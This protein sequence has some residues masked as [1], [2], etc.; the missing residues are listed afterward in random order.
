MKPKSTSCAV[1]IPS[2][3]LEYADAY[4]NAMF[5]ARF[6]YQIPSASATARAA[7][8]A[9]IQAERNYTMAI[10][11]ERDALRKLAEQALEALRPLNSGPLRWYT[12]VDAAIDALRKVLDHE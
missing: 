6:S 1:N 8:K 5:N 9:E 12:P 2:K 11:S 7:L 4:A 3:V 10:L